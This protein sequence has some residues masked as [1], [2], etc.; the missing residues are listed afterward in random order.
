MP[1][2]IVFSN[3]VK[4]AVQFLLFIVLMGFYFMK[5]E[6]V[7]PNLCILLFP[8]IMFLMALL[9]LGL[10]L[11]V[12]AATTKYRDLVFLVTFGVQLIMYGSAVISPIGL[13]TPKYVMLIKLNPLSGLIETF[14]YGFIGAGH[15]YPKT[16][17][18]SVVANVVIFM[19]GLITFNRVEKNFVD[20]V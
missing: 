4:F 11:I 15:F 17:A 2:S 3:L 16:F 13:T 10:G 20:T 12:T 6:K 14:R 7:H 19:I 9:S 1:L 5:G 18:Y 8:V